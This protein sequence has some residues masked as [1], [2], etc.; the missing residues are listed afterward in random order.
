MGFSVRIHLSLFLLIL[1]L[2]IPCSLLGVIFFRVYG[3]TTEES[4]W[5][6]I[7]IVKDPPHIEAEKQ[8]KTPKRNV[9][10]MEKRF[11]VFEI[12]RVNGMLVPLSD[13]R[14]MLME[15]RH[16]ALECLFLPEKHV[17]SSSFARALKLRNL[18]ETR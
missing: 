3:N 7:L 1:L 5:D 18:L 14:F 12:S 9:D 4:D 17:R 15:H 8:R 2:T 6:F 13:F 10:E 16:E 11:P